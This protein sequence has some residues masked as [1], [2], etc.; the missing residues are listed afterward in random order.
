M[1]QQ[2]EL[3]CKTN[4]SYIFFLCLTID[5]FNILT[6]QLPVLFIENPI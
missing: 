4:E 2:S 1:E 3:R 6:A 5:L